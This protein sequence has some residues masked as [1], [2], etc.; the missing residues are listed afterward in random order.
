LKP[1]QAAPFVAA[2]GLERRGWGLPEL[3]L[4]CASHSGEQRHLELAASMLADCG[5]DHQQ[6]LCGCQI[7]IAYSQS[8]RL[9]AADE[10]FTALHHNCSGKH[11][12]FLAACLHHGD[13]IDDY[14][15]MDHPLQRRIRQSLRQALNP[16][17]AFQ[18]GIDGCAAPNLAMPLPQLARLFAVLASE[19]P[20]EPFSAV[21]GDAPQRCFSAMTSHPDL[22][23]GTDRSDLIMMQI[24][25]G[26][27][28]CK[29]GAEAVQAIGIRSRGLGIAVKIA[30]GNARAML[31]VMVEVLRQLAIADSDQIKSMQALVDRPIRNARGDAVG[32]YQPVFALSRSD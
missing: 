26:D 10:V 15:A 18:S 5:L 22:V 29:A 7:P 1:F 13:P 12:G 21:Y 23:S 16:D 25:A 14:V 30:D 28:V 6:L 32:R 4:M 9:P 2:G 24:G 27:W 19:H 17:T 11:S 3:A 20:P 8:G 31:W